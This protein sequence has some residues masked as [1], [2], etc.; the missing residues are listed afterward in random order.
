MRLLALAAILVLAACAGDAPVAGD[1]RARAE[2]IALDTTA[3]AWRHAVGVDTVFMAGDTAVVWVSPRDWLATDA[4]HAGVHVAP[5]GR[6][7]SIEWILGG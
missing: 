7:T 4:P 6:I 5:G 3:K 1:F 2:R